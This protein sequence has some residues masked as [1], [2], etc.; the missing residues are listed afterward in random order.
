MPSR[1][2]Y[3]KGFREEFCIDLIHSRKVVH[4]RKVHIDLDNMAKGGSAGLKNSGH[5]LDGLRLRRLS[6]GSWYEND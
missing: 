1:D 4:G 3:W 2:A 5:V 6:V